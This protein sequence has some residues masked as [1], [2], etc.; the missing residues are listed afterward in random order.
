MARTAN[1]MLKRSSESGHPC[2]VPD[3]SRKS[4]SFSSLSIRLVLGLPLIAFIMLRYV[5]SI[6]TLFGKSF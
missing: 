4:F 2:L 5:P 6:P 1:T 3:F